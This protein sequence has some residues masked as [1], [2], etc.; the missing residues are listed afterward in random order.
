MARR[1]STSMISTISPSLHDG[2][3]FAHMAHDREVVGDHDIGQPPP[4][5]QI[6]EQVQD[7][8]LDRHIKGR[9]WFI[10]QQDQV[11]V[12][13]RV[14]WRR[15]AADRLTAGA[16][17]ETGSCRQAPHH[18]SSLTTPRVNVPKTMQMSGF[19]KHLIDRV[20]GV[21]RR[22]WVLK[23]HLNGF[24]KGFGPLFCDRIASRQRSPRTNP[25]PSP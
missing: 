19:A 8:C 12:P 21:Q 14:R 17:S 11:R 22:V 2:K 4:G 15:A 3:V 9:C 7:L 24:V 20:P 10:Q 5:P 25:T 16:D 23:H 13:R 18:P 6:G 1:V